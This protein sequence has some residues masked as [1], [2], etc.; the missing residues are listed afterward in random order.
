MRGSHRTVPVRKAPPCP[1]DDP[2]NNA[3]SLG[4]NN[5]KKLKK[6]SYPSA[7][8]SHAQQ[9]PWARPFTWSQHREIIT[10]LYI[11]DDLPLKEVEEIMREEF[12]FHATQKMY[13]DHFRKWGLRKNLS[14][15]FVEDFLRR[16]R[17]QNFSP[18]AHKPNGTTV[19]DR[20]LGRRMNRYLRSGSGCPNAQPTHSVYGMGVPRQFESPGSLRHA[21]RS[22]RSFLQDERPTLGFAVINQC[23]A[24]FKGMLEPNPWLIL[25]AFYGAFD[26]ARHDAQLATGFIQYIYKLTTLKNHAFHDLFTTLLQ[27]GPEGIVGQFETVILGYFMDT[28]A[29]SFRDKTMVLDIMRSF[30]RGFIKAFPMAMPTFKVSRATAQKAFDSLKGKPDSLPI[31]PVPVNNGQPSS[32]IEAIVSFPKSPMEDFLQGWSNTRPPPPTSP[33]PSASSSSTMTATAT[34][35][36]GSEWQDSN[37]AES[38][39]VY[40]PSIVLK[41]MVEESSVELHSGNL[42]VTARL[43]DLKECFGNPTGKY[44]DIKEL[45]PAYEYLMKFYMENS[46]NYLP[47]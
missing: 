34:S 4:N 29:C 21:E 8:M 3:T 10:Q 28:M 22:S 7:V 46:S 35:S 9:Q 36:I 18:A 31:P 15:Q 25:A 27:S 43:M 45:R 40:D 13:K 24:M 1:K 41:K 33:S 6:V 26:L 2:N 30:S 39:S 17:Q 38:P 44:S 47:H 37:M 20:N 14:S 11:V 5:K 42:S 19:V 32:A 23:L 16:G 12:Q